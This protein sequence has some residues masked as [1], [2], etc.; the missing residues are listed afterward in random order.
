[1]FA[2]ISKFLYFYYILWWKMCSLTSI[3]MWNVVDLPGWT[4]FGGYIMGKS[5]W[6][7]IEVVVCNKEG[8]II[9]AIVIM[10]TT[11][12]NPKFSFF[13]TILTPW[14]K[15][16]W[17]SYRQCLELLRNNSRVEKLYH[18]IAK[19][20]STPFICWRW[21]LLWHSVAKMGVFHL[22]AK[23]D[24]DWILGRGPSA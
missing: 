22:Y 16:L 9:Y 19:K 14:V 17:E 11:C 7:S 4:N 12:L 15:F 3:N 13:R 23:C 20:V 6:I 2:R 8:T 18:E 24:L 5:C 1:M 10:G 21:M